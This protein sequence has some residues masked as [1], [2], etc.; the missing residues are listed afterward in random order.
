MTR[1]CTGVFR[2]IGLLSATHVR[3][4]LLLGCGSSVR[5]F[6]LIV[7]KIE[8]FEGRLMGVSCPPVVEILVGCMYIEGGRC[9][10]AA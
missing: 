2:V 3:R 8:F 10:R 7:L 1:V 9:I 6:V 5:V 4:G